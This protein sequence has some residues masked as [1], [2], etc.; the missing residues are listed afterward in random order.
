MEEGESRV[1]DE[2]PAGRSHRPVLHGSDKLFIAPMT[3]RDFFR[4]IIRIVQVTCCPLATLSM[5]DQRAELDR[6][7][8]VHSKGEFPCLASPPKTERR[9]STRIGVRVSRSSSA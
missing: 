3:A 5:S 9:S 4:A 8:P 6:H 7:I 1:R 2:R